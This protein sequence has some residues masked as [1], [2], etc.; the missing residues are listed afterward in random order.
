MT[1]PRGLPARPGTYVLVIRNKQRLV[2]EAGRL[3]SCVLPRGWYLYTGSAFGPGG[4][5]ARAGRHTV[6]DK[7]RRWHIDYLT[8]HLPVSRV[9]L[10][11][12]PAKLECAWAEVL[13]RMGGVAAVPGFG[14][15][16]CRCEGHLLGFSSRPSFSIFRNLVGH[17]VRSVKIS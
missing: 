5:A 7:P 12:A 3:G 13:T 4:L 15:S 9:W 10:T 8:G 16:D 17:P 11:T 1:V 2:F 6:Q 14:S